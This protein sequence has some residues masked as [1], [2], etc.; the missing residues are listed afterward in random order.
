MFLAQ[1]IRS[2]RRK[3][4]YPHPKLSLGLVPYKPFYLK[5]MQ[6][7]EILVYSYV[8]VLACTKGSFIS[9]S[10]EC[11]NGLTVCV[12]LIVC[13]QLIIERLKQ[14]ATFLTSPKTFGLLYDEA[15]GAGQSFGIGASF[16]QMIAMATITTA[17]G[18]MMCHVQLLWQYICAPKVYM[19]FISPNVVM[20]FSV[21]LE[22]KQNSP[23]EEEAALSLLKV[24]LL[25]R[26][27]QRGNVSTLTT[28]TLIL[29]STLFLIHAHASGIQY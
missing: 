2:R 27:E 10:V 21:Y 8:F 25:P 26:C 15:T 22:L 13:P 16:N 12:P 9:D 14:E 23:P 3:L 20:C 5:Q 29:F 18:C 7:V 11:S 17:P 24:S 28:T 19:C 1:W 6:H 4:L